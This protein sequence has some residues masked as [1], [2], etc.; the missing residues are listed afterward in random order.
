MKT[1]LVD[2]SDPVSILQFLFTYKQAFESHR[3]HESVCIWCLKQFMTKSVAASIAT[4]MYLKNEKSLC[5][6]RGML[7]SWEKVVIHILDMYTTDDI[8][9]KSGM[10]MQAFK[11]RRTRFPTTSQKPCGRRLSDVA[12]RIP[13]TLS[14]AS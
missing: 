14:G 3:I 9:A 5:K 11:C 4:R 8:I 12:R 10:S 13:N 2:P 7:S 1:S 6:P